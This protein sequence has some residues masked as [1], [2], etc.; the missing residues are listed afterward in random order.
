MA[1]PLVDL[2]AEYMALKTGLDAAASRVLASGWYILGQEVAAFEAEFAAYLG[3]AQA[4][5][6]ASGTDAVL[7][8]CRA[9]EIGPGDEVITVAHTAVATIAAIELSG[10]TPLFVDIDPQTYTLDVTQIEAAITPRTRAIMPV[11]LYGHPAGMAAILAIARRHQLLVIEDCAQAHGASYQG[12]RVGSMGDAAAFSFY[13]T[14]N[15]GAIGDGG[16]VVT[17]NPAVAERLKMLRQYGWRER[18]IS[19]IAGYNSRLDELQAALLRVKLAHLEQFNEARRR[20]AAAYQEQLAGLPLTLPIIQPGCEPVFHL[21]V[22]QSGQRNELQKYLAN[23]GIGTAIQYPVP[24]HRQPAYHRLGYAAN[25]L[26]ITEQVC[27]RIL[28][29]PLHPHLT[30][31]Q[32]SRVSQTIRS[33]YHNG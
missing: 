4:V 32:I 8:A 5:G 6:V 31:K 19:D 24:V 9:L 25:S 23:Q 22:I 16:A 26:P 2:Q 3:V 30:Q 1:I 20:L 21:Y 7:L 11:H 28:S 17:N 10:A 33:F 15:L 27:G 18:Y 13:P 14:K 29:L 12:Q